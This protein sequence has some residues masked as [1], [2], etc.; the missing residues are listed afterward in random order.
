M[1]NIE[2][3]LSI[4]SPTSVHSHEE[5]FART[6]D[7]MDRLSKIHPLLSEI[8]F[9]DSSVGWEHMLNEPL[10]T[11]VS[12]AEWITRFNKN[13]SDKPH[14]GSTISFWNRNSAIDKKFIIVG[15]YNCDESEAM[16]NNFV[17]FHPFVKALI[18][19]NIVDSMMIALIDSFA[20]Y[21]GFYNCTY[22]EPENYYTSIYKLWLKHGIPYPE[23]GEFARMRADHPPHELSEPWHGGTR[24]TW[25]QYEP[26]A[27]LGLE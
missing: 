16:H 12:L 25:P 10:I 1:S 17:I 2:L 22:Y 9:A 23:G 20:A 6:L 19:P 5:N 3:W 13:I 8:S 18:E 26:R 27:F 24:Y 7:L 11:E 21:R 4:D 14:L 15:K